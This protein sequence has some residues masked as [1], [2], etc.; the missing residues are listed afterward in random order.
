MTD[1]SQILQKSAR[2]SFFAPMILH[3]VLKKFL[4][5]G[6][7]IMLLPD[8]KKLCI[9]TDRPTVTARIHDWKTVWQIL[10][11]PDLRIGEAYMDGRLTFSK[12]DVYDFL[13]LCLRNLDR[14]KGLWV[15]KVQQG[16]RML[17]RRLMMHNP[18]AKSQKNVAHHYDLS[19]RLY[20]LFLDA[21]RQYSCAYY[22]SASDTLETAQAAKKQHI[23]E[24]LLLEPGQ[25]VLDIGCGWGGLDRFLAETSD[26][27]VTGITLS[28]EQLG[29]AK[30]QIQKKDM[31]DKVRV[32]LKDYRQESGQFDRVVSV[33]MFEHLGAGYYKPYFDK[34]K[35][36]LKDDGV[37]LVHT[38]GCANPP[39][40][41]H[42]WIAKYI[43][44]GGYIP[45][46]SEIMP[47]IEQSG[48]IVTDV[49]VLRLH[50]AMT[51][52][53]WRERFM[54]NQEEIREIYD[55]RFCRMWEFY[56]AACEAGFRHSGLVVFQIQLA[57]KLDTVPLT[58]DYLYNKNT[59]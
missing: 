41:P 30:K 40:A 34:I 36:L 9:G 43:F 24:K 15:R 57:N 44:P 26:V 16:M 21:D 55:D 13:D 59:G 22:P 39:S 31:A 2:R 28:E 33:G 19:D 27:E 47:A 48:L 8:G 11:N 52:R 45:S 50:Y 14:G 23:A 51:L 20:E 29:Y 35:K 38:I 12:G 42:P 49:E 56:L 3:N 18:I 17:C 54:Q 58:R 1:Q 5:K 46:L 10:L 7:L 53:D 4:V 37:A 32:F 25:S 6:G